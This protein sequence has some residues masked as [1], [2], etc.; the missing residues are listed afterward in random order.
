MVEY[1]RG[2]IAKRSKWSGVSLRRCYGGSVRSGCVGCLAGLV[3]LLVVGLGIGCTAWAL[4]RALD[5]PAQPLG[6]AGATADGARAQ[7]KVYEIVRRAYGGGRQGD[8]VT[9]T[10]REINALLT[11]HVQDGT[12]PLDHP[13]VKLVGAGVADIAGR[14]PL[15]QLLTDPPIQSLSAILPTSWRDRPVWVRIEGRPQIDAGAGAGRGQRYLRIDMDRAWIGRQRVPTTLLKVMLSPSHL[16]AL[17]WPVPPSIDAVS[18]EP[19]RL[20]VM[21]ASAR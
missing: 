2:R 5:S 13:S 15:Q 17:N 10:E 20:V 9:L 8:R 21:I 11:R 4:V 18:V 1:F 7:Q 12:L 19:G 6:S 16:R 3:L 14:L